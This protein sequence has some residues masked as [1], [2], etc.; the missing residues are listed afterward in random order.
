M[1]GVHRRGRLA[2]YVYGVLLTVVL[3]PAAYAQTSATFDLEEQRQRAQQQAIDRERQAQAPRVDLESKQPA[4]AIDNGRVPDEFPCFKVEHIGIEL[5][6]GLSDLVRAAGERALSPDPLFP[7]ELRF[8]SDYLQRYVGQCIGR[9]GLN[10]IVYRLADR[11]LKKGYTTTRV[12]IPAQDLSTGNLKLEIVP[13]VI[14]AIRFAAPDVY[15]T[16]RNAFP[17]HAGNLLNLRDLETGLEQMKR[18]SNQDVDM[19]IVPGEA[20]G[21]SDV[22]ITVTRT[23]PWSLSVSLDDSGL[24]STGQLQ[25]ST[26]L[27]I[28]NPLGLS[29]IFNIGYSHDANGHADKY[30]TRGANAYYSLPF[31]NWT[32]T[33]SASQYHYHQL[34]AGAFSDIVSSGLSKTFDLKAEYLFHRNQ[35]QKNSLEFRTGK[36]FSESAVDGSEIEVQHRDN[37]YAEVGWVHKHYVGDAQLDSTIAYRWGVPWFGAQADLPNSPTF[38][39]HIQTIDSTLTVPFKVGN[40][41]LRYT[42]TVRAQNSSSTLYATEFF[43]IGSRYTVRGFDGERMLSAEKGVF[44][45]NDLEMPIASTTNSVYLGLDGGEVF[46]PSAGQLLGRRLAGAVIGLRG[47]PVKHVFYDMFIGG[48]LYEPDRFPNHWP[49]AGFSLSF[50]L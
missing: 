36:Y 7:G 1:S 49:V 9:E 3:I 2:S 24:R 26:N 17:T 27:A 40:V 30:G 45:R 44:M 20:T 15:G 43:S 21:E 25:A 46:G 23:K 47:S 34:V 39:Y 13:G 33:A 22:V 16:W 50:Q 48:P 5:P 29:D 4:A 32:F 11:I 6:S 18:V 28:N 37:S 10:L 42:A 35:V 8:T 12:L 14:G 31:G 38:Y 19:Q 41:P